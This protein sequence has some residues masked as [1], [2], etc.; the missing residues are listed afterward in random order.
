MSHRRIQQSKYWIVD[1]IRPLLVWSELSK[2]KIELS[3]CICTIL[4]YVW[5]LRD[6]NYEN[7]WSSTSHKLLIV[8]PVT[9]IY[10]YYTGDYVTR[11]FSYSKDSIR[12]IFGYLRQIRP[13]RFKPRVSYRMDRSW[14]EVPTIPVFWSFWFLDIVLPPLT[15]LYSCLRLQILWV[16]LL[17]DLT[18]TSSFS[19]YYFWTLSVYYICEMN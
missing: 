4:R 18:W 6:K 14:R 2:N 10:L 8:P 19:C 13:I 5:M 12:K 3:P 9:T 7:S 1:V 15:S 17:M 11:F 16:G